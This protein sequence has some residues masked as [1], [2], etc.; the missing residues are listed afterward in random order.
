MIS[1]T[2][3]LYL[4]WTLALASVLG[5]LYFSEI[6]GLPPCVLC[7]WQRIL[8][9]PLLVILTVAIFRKDD[10]V[11]FYS[12]PLSILG[13]GTAMY[14]YLLQNGIIPEEA[15][16]CLAGVSCV[17][18]QIELLGFITIPL[19]AFAAFTV[20]TISL[21]LYRRMKL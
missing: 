19:M 5:S 9:Y 11:F 20:I 1:R 3:L 10:N 2:N 4:A 21:I 7:W 15:G 6:A 8:M 16:P 13:M 17:D 18:K 12:L 14:H